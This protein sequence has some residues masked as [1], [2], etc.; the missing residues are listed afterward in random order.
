[1]SFRS[2]LCKEITQVDKASERLEGPLT[3]RGE[4]EMAE[5]QATAGNK[6]YPL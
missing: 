2:R 6:S 1:M 3:S 4:F 5:G